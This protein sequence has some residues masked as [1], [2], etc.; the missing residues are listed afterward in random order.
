VANSGAAGSSS[1]TGTSAES[2][3]NTGPTTPPSPTPA[4]CRVS[5]SPYEKDSTILFAGSEDSTMLEHP[6]MYITMQS[7]PLLARGLEQ[8]VGPHV[9]LVGDP[10][11]DFDTCKVTDNVDPKTRINYQEKKDIDGRTTI[12]K[13]DLSGNA[14]PNDNVGPIIGRDNYDKNGLLTSS[15]IARSNFADPNNVNTAVGVGKDGKRDITI[16]QGDKPIIKF[17][18][19]KSGYILPSNSFKADPEPEY[20]NKGQIKSRTITDKN[21]NTVKVDNVETYRG[22]EALIGYKSIEAKKS[23]GSIITD[24]GM[25]PK[26]GLYDKRIT[27]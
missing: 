27:H 22:G 13:M 19:T 23:D 1:N 6:L 5:Y 24:V 7:P 25:N 17:T 3:V 12:D 9:Q 10:F 26:G 18:M 2:P 16:T 15:T 14:S 21:G 4:T 20:N 8:S 11:V